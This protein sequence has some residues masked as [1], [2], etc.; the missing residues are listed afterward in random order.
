MAALHVLLGAPP[1]SPALA[2]LVAGATGY[3]P[4]ERLLLSHFAVRGMSP[5]LALLAMHHWLGHPR[6]R[7]A[8]ARTSAGRCAHR[9][10]WPWK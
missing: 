10:H 5:A 4:I 8:A 9:V 3:C 7:S 2:A 1:A 6:V